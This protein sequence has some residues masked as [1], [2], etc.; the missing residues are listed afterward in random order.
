MV[1]SPPDSAVHEISPVRI[2][3]YIAISFSDPT[4]NHIRSI[5]ELPAHVFDEIMH[6]FK[7]YKQLERKETD[8]R[9]LH[10][11]DKAIAII[12]GTEKEED[13]VPNLMQGFGIDEIQADY[14]ADIKLRNLNR[15]YILNRIMESEDLEAEIKQIKEIL[16]DE[17]KLK[18]LI[19]KQLGEIKK[20]YGV[21]RRTQLLDAAEAV[22]A[23][24]VEEVENY[25]VRL[26]LTKEGY[27]KKI[28]LRSLQGS[29]EQ[30]FKEGDYLLSEA[31]TDNLSSLLF[32]TDGRRMFRTQT[33]N[34]DCVKASLMGDYLPAKL[35]MDLQSGEKPVFMQIN[36]TYSDKEYF[37]FIFENGKGV[38][39]AASNYQTQGN[40]SKLTGAFSGSSP[41]AAVLYEKKP[42]DITLVSDAGRAI[43]VSTS[44]I[45]IAATRTA[46][47]VTLMSLKKGQKVLEATAAD[48]NVYEAKGTRKLKIPAT[49]VALSPADVKKL[50]E[51]FPD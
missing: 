6:F 44:M 27:F 36:P 46:G 14:I 37:V 50:K 28:T 35:E 25:N 40:R 47:G 42:F 9:N 18:G 17:L 39:V 10:G 22:S 30:K 41:I 24:V 21:P 20:K 45:P 5:E 51:R 29:D 16:G 12:R 48:A 19:A 8:I 13:V 2:L 1:C 7:V 33:K 4:Y 31:E 34:F 49:G 38:R 32:V 23:P 15:Q 43:T 11:P 3:E 26:Y